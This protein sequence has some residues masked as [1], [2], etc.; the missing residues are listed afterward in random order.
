MASTALT[1]Q[2]A[3]IVRSMNADELPSEAVAA[4]LGVS[5]RTVQRIPREQLAYT[6]TPGGPLRKG[7]RKYRR[8]DVEAY[9]ATYLGRGTN[10]TQ[11]RH[12]AQGT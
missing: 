1:A 12:K 4:L 2:L 7:H 8:E 5:R 10:A 11:P 6:T 9:A 3:D